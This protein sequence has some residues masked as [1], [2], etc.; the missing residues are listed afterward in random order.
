MPEPEREEPTLRCSFCGKTQH[1][2]KALVAGPGVAICEAC[3][4][5]CNGVIAAIPEGAER[6]PVKA[7][8]LDAYPTEQMLSMLGGMAKV[9]DDVSDRLRRSVDI[10]RSRKVSWEAIGKA[11]GVSRQAAW[12]R[13]S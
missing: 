8:W 6:K 9:Y 7:D 10:L 12:E 13:F 4:E 3:V 11:L 5:L 1:K 2:V